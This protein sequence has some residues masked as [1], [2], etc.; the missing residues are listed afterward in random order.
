M[1][2]PFCNSL[3]FSLLQIHPDNSFLSQIPEF[4]PKLIL[5]IPETHFGSV[6]KNTCR[7]IVRYWKNNSMRDEVDK[8]WLLQHFT[9]KTILSLDSSVKQ[10]V[11]M[12]IVIQ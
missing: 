5:F 8:D 1:E 12:A 11:G 4:L 10:R 3:F 9:A 6:M 2:A 7:V